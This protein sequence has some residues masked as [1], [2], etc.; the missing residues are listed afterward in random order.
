MM[1]PR[2]TTSA[3]VEDNTVRNWDPTFYGSEF[4][5]SLPVKQFTFEGDGFDGSL[6][7]GI[8]GGWGRSLEKGTTILCMTDYVTDEIQCGV[9]GSDV[10]DAFLL[11]PGYIGETK[12]WSDRGQLGLAT[13][14]YVRLGYSPIEASLGVAA[15]V[16]SQGYHMQDTDS[17]LSNYS[18]SPQPENGLLNID[19]GYSPFVAQT[20]GLG[21]SFKRRSGDQIIVSATAGVDAT[22]TRGLKRTMSF[23]VAGVLGH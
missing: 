2:V 19:R 12:G 1:N 9:Y 23:S 7:V 6:N 17:P 15:G 21:V 14:I 22:K 8:M 5:V 16:D 18:R 10:P 20:V 4:K 3:I 13:D 11:G